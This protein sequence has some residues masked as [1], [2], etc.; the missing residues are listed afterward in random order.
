MYYFSLK[1]KERPAVV[2]YTPFKDVDI[3][4]YKHVAIIEPNK[5]VIHS[6]VL[7]STQFPYLKNVFA[8]LIR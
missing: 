3:Y 8:H 6:L 1:I 4:L 7:P 2:S 5:K